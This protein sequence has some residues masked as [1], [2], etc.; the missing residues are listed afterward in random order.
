MPQEEGK[1]AKKTNA[2]ARIGK[3]ITG[4]FKGIPEG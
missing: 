2:L 1:T 3:L 4:L